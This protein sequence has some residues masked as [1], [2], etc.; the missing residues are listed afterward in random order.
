MKKSIWISF[1]FVLLFV[2]CVQ[3]KKSAFMVIDSEAQKSNYSQ[4]ISIEPLDGVTFEKNTIII[5]PLQEN[6][7]YTLTGYFN[8]QIISKTK[9]T[10]LKL[11]NVFL[12][13]KREKPALK[14][15]EKA[16]ISAVGGTKNYIRSWGRGFAKNAALQARKSLVIGGS[17]ILFVQGDLCHGVEADK[18]K[19]KGSGDFY[20]QG[21]KRGSAI[22]CKE[23]T[24]EDDK[25]FKL[26]LLNSKNAV[27]S[28]DEIT[29]KSGNF[30]LYDNDNSFVTYAPDSV[31]IEKSV[32]IETK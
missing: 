5:A 8:G 20:I 28:D 15:T 21:T 32:K 7:T 30:Y 12:E 17:G 16:E 29:I 14:A 3:S 24:V 6:Q 26:W 22:R 25:S 1:A 2:S 19:I 4:P 10:I 18:L 13:N 9:N 27:K 31:H 11:Q 23:L